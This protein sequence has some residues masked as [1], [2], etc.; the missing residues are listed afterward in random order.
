[1]NALIPPEELL[2]DPASVT[3]LDVR[4]W[5]GRSDG[6]AEY[7]AGHL[8]GAAYVDLETDL[9]DPPGDRGRHPLPDLHRF[10]EAMRRCGVSGSRGVVVYDDGGGGAARA[11]WLLRYHGHLDVRLLDGSWSEW[12]RLGGPAD[13]GVETP[14][15]GDFEPVPGGLPV[16]DAAGAAELGRHGVLVDARIPGRFRGEVEPVDPVAGRIP[17]AINVPQALNLVGEGPGAGRF[18]PV[19]ELRSAYRPVL[20]APGEVAVYCGSGV[21]AAHDVL[22]LDLLGVRAALYPGSWSEWITDP[23]RP[24]ARG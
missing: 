20:E 3:L 5:L 6:R 1:V 7:E 24:V 15:Y 2:A 13:T 14:A 8:P 22:A 12:C 17:G 4:W 16:V 11:W 23:S 18:R 9:A 21:T 10:G 19:E